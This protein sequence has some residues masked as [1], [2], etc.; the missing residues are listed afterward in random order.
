MPV[1]LPKLL[2]EH[3]RIG[4]QLLLLGFRREVAGQDV[5]QITAQHCAAQ[6]S[7]P[8]VQA[9][10][11]VRRQDGH[12][13]LHVNRAGIKAGFHAHQGDAGDIVPGQYGVLDWRSPSPSRQQRG[14]HVV[15]A[16]GRQFQYMR[17]QDLTKSSYNNGLRLPLQQWPQRLRRA[18][19]WRLVD[20]DAGLC[21]QLLD[22]R[23]AQ[24]PASSRRPVRLSDHPDH[25]L[26]FQ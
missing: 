4:C 20:R 10:R 23:R 14:V 21:S 13:F 9:A 7:Q 12:R 16:Q 25:V 15:A 11:R 26:R 6:L 18:Q 1:N 5:I 8:V 3:G 24:L 22:R 2:L 19:G 17:A